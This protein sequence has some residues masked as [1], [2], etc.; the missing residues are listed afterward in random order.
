MFGGFL[1]LFLPVF[2]VLLGDFAAAL[3]LAG[4]LELALVL[5]GLASADALAIV[6]SGAIVDFWRLF[7]GSDL[8]GGGVGV[9]RGV[10]AIGITLP[11]GGTAQ[12]A[13][14]GGGG[15]DFSGSILH[16]GDTIEPVRL[17]HTACDRLKGK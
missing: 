1:L 11:N 3:A 15:Q 8:A 12:K 5:L 10:G 9:G 4:V 2:D 16:I 6:Q 14:H 7:E 17:C 13:R